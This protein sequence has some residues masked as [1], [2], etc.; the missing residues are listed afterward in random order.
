MST[1]H[2]RPRLRRD[3]WIDLCGAWQFRYDDDNQGVADRWY[4]GGQPYD[5][6]ITV[7]FPPESALSGIGDPAPHPICWYRRDVRISRGARERVLLHFGAVDYGADLWVNGRHLLHH[8]GGHTPFV[9]DIT[10]CL[11]PS[12]RQVIDLRAEDV[13]S[14]VSQPRG[15]QDWQDHPHAIWY[16]R[17]SGIWQPVWLERVPETYIVNVQFVPDLPTGSV[18]VEIT[19]SSAPQEELA[20][21]V[22]L[23]ADGRRLARQTLHM[24]ERR[25]RTTLTLPDFDNRQ[26]AGRL[27]WSPEQPSLIEADLRLMSAPD[28]APDVVHSYFGMRSCGVGDGAFLLNGRPYFVRSVLSQGFW[29]TSHLAAPDDDAIRREVEAIKALGF[30]AVRCHQ[31]VEDPRFL[32]WCDRLGVLVWGEMP[33]AYAFTP[34]MIARVTAEWMD[35]VERDRSHPCVVTWVPI[36]ESWGIDAVADRADQRAFATALHALSKAIDPTRPVISNDGWEHTVSDIVGIHDYAGIP[37]HLR[38]TY[39]SRA[40]LEEMAAGFGPQRRRVL[41]SGAGDR[42]PVFMVTEFGGLSY[43]PASGQKWFGYSTVTSKESYLDRLAGLFGA[44]LDS[45]VLAGFCYTQLTDTMQ[46]TNGLL[47]EN[48]VPK[49][50]IEAIHAIVSRPSEALRA[51]YLDVERRRALRRAQVAVE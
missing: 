38:Q 21:E 2:P 6:T 26:A 44:L 37:D 40:G 39:A 17:T 13:A 32:S 19:L 7:P 18:A 22:V 28:A 31:K 1:S 14:D 8:D 4:E 9:A 49:L 24:T 41:L 16:N 36:N 15:K 23:S 51:E 5:R 35:V 50:P 12:G 25:Q 29:P 33:S 3:D 11:D 47:D 34:G 30:N 43:H 42:K 45:P 46:E 48:R 27:I 20:C 10:D